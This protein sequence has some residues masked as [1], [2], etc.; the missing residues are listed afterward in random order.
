[1]LATSTHDNKRSEDVRARINVLSEMPGAWRLSL[2]RWSRLNQRR[3]TLVGDEPAPSRNDE[4]LLYQILLGAWPLEEMD[5]AGL[6]AFRE[7]IQAYMLKAAREAKVKTSWINPNEEYERALSSF[8]AALLKER[9]PFLNDFLPAQKRI[10]HYGMLNGLSQT[11]IKLASP[12]IPDIYQGS[13][14]WDLSLVDPD[15]RRPVNYGRRSGSLEQMRKTA[16]EHHGSLA[17]ELLA[18]MHDGRIKQYVTW[19]T[20][21]LRAQLPDLFGQGDYTALFA[22]GSKS[23]HV[24]AFARRHDGRAAVAVAPRLV[25]KLTAGESTLPLGD[26]I[27]EETRLPLPE[28]GTYVDAF[29]GAR[30]ETA[31]DD[32]LPLSRVLAT[33]PVALLVSTA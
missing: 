25:L 18:S 17:T 27:W 4:Y 28:A 6:E 22:Q 8:I 32:G 20:L 31:G 14:L 7:R 11:L 33:F 5:A 29:T 26:A 16:P 3:K 24:C 19:K 21:S 30:H 9:S 15:N 1:M 23:E 12:G 13:E 2:R 10:A